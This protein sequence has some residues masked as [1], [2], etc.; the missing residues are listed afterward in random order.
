MLIDVNI[1]DFGNTLEFLNSA[2]LTDVTFRMLGN[3]LSSCSFRVY[4]WGVSN[5]VGWMTN[6]RMHLLKPHV[7]LKTR[8]D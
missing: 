4:T 1:V 5:A 7:T 3:V 6:E 2:S 8:S